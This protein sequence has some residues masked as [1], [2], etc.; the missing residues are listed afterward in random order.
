M[1]IPVQELSHLLI[2]WVFL[3]VP[4]RMLHMCM[5]MWGSHTHTWHCSIWPWKGRYLLW[6]SDSYCRVI[7]FITS[8]SQTSVMTIMNL[9]HCKSSNFKASAVVHAV[10]I[11]IVFI[12]QLNSYWVKSTCMYRSSMYSKKF[13]INDLISY[14]VQ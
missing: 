12:A 5:H 8:Y 6:S 14:T 4:I 9:L 11:I 10:V 7:I 13:N 1:C 3:Q 2:Q